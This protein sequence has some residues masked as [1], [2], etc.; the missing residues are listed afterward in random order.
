MN[1]KVA[2]KNDLVF[3][4]N[5]QFHL[6]KNKGKKLKWWSAYWVAQILNTRWK[7]QSNLCLL[8][9]FVQAGCD[10]DEMCN[11]FVPSKHIFEQSSRNLYGP[12]HVRYLPRIRAYEILDEISIDRSGKTWIPRVKSTTMPTFEECVRTRCVKVNSVLV[13]RVFVRPHDR[14]VIAHTQKLNR[15]MK[16]AF[17]RTLN[18]SLWTVNTESIR[19]VN[20][21]ILSEFSRVYMYCE[22]DEEKI[23]ETIVEVRFAVIVPGKSFSYDEDNDN[24]EGQ[25]RKDWTL[26]T[27]MVAFEEKL[28]SKMCGENFSSFCEVTLLAFTPVHVRS[29]IPVKPSSLKQRFL[30]KKEEHDDDDDDDD[31]IVVE[32]YRKG[33]YVYFA[34]P[35]YDPHLHNDDDDQNDPFYVGRVLRANELGIYTL[36]VLRRDVKSIDKSVYVEPTTNKVVAYVRENALK[37]VYDLF[38]DFRNN[39]H[40]VTELN[41]FVMTLDTAAV[42]MGSNNLHLDEYDEKRASTRR[43]GVGPS[44]CKRY[45]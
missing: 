31:D 26:E 30:E 33:S 14:D 41:P 38:R 1:G 3:L 24:E 12:L 7:N 29:A 39:L 11:T 44:V 2:R 15:D 40:C 23:E 43:L 18:A 4:P 28:R 21:S 6:Y 27:L 5:A 37:P 22:K 19:V 32:L 45:L 25:S 10:D 9:L 36:Q 42:A 35:D 13:I 8:R 16:M 17:R 34:N 20:T